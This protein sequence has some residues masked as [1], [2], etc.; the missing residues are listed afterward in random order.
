MSQL[1][2]SHIIIIGMSGHHFFHCGDDTWKIN[3]EIML[4]DNSFS[5]MNNLI[6]Y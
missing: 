1:P 5:I 3:S 2:S 4:G 6:W